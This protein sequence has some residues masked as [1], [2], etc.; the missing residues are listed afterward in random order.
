MTDLLLGIG[1]VLAVEGLLLAAF[2]AFVRRRMAEMQALGENTLRAAG[3]ASAVGGVIL[4]WL[5]RRVLG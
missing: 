4:V 3:L 5:A 1:L 2:P